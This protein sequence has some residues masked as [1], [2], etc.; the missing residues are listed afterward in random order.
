MTA[1]QGRKHFYDLLKKT[2][3]SGFVVAITH[4]GVPKMVAMS[5]DQYET[6]M[7][8]LEI[9]SDP[10]LDKEVRAAARRAKSGKRLIGTVTLEQLKKELRR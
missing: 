8:Q 5:F 6:L 7:E 4:E 2:G 10:E 9:L 3:Q 1:T